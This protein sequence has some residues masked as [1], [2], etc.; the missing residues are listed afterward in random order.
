MPGLVPSDTCNIWK[1]KFTVWITCNVHFDCPILPS[2][3][4]GAIDLRRCSISLLSEYFFEIILCWSL[5]KGTRNHSSSR[6]HTRTTFSSRL[7]EVLA[8]SRRSQFRW[9]ASLEGNGINMVV[10]YQYR[11]YLTPEITCT[12]NGLSLI[13]ISCILNHLLVYC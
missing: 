8:P 6:I 12:E 7:R 10:Q 2:S 5:R 9:L 4:K 13:D 3:V 11:T 1:F